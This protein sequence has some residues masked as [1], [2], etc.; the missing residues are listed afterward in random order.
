MI[1]SRF[2]L[3]VCWEISK[4]KT[5]EGRNKKEQKVHFTSPFRFYQTTEVEYYFTM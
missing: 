1:M 2:S 4:Q 5:I 3:I